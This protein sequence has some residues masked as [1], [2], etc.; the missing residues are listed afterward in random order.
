MFEGEIINF[1]NKE[2]QDA[3]NIRFK[4]QGGLLD[5]RGPLKPF[6][7]GLEP[8]HGVAGLR[9]R[10]F[11]GAKRLQDLQSTGLL[12]LQVAEADQRPDQGLLGGLQEFGAAQLVRGAM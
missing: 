3:G 10:K 5:L 2:C 4:V 6:K 8:V 11:Q 12:S 9:L 1:D 7:E